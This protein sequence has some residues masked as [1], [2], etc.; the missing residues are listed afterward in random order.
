MNQHTPEEIAQ[1]HKALDVAM[2]G[3]IKL[4]SIPKGELTKKDVFD[5]ASTMI[6][7]GAFPQ[8]EDKQHLITALASLPDDEEGIRQA[9]GKQILA[10]SAFQQ[11]Y[12]S[13]FGAPQ[14]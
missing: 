1:G 8:P 13:V 10:M 3:L 14:Q 12:H 7:H 11:Q 6:A 9:L 2:G 4:V 5:E